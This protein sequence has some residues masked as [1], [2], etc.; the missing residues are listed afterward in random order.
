MNIINDINADTPVQAILEAEGTN[1]RA[2]MTRLACQVFN[3]SDGRILRAY[4]QFS[5]QAMATLI[6]A[7][8]KGV[9]DYGETIRKL[10]VGA[11][12]FPNNPKA[13]LEALDL[14][15]EGE[16]D[17]VDL[18][19]MDLLD[20][21]GRPVIDTTRL[22]PTM[23]KP[24][25]PKPKAEKPKE[26]GPTEA[27]LAELKAEKEAAERKAAEEE[28]RRHEA[29]KAEKAEEKRRQEVMEAQRQ[30]AEEPAA[31]VSSDPLSAVSI[32]AEKVVTPIREHIANLS[33]NLGEVLEGMHK[34]NTEAL[35]ALQDEMN[36]T[37]AQTDVR[38]NVIEQNQVALAKALQTFDRNVQQILMYF[39]DP[40][41]EFEQLPL[42]D[43]QATESAAET[44]ESAA[45]TSP[46]ESEESG[47]EPD[48]KGSTVE[49]ASEHADDGDEEDTVKR[50]TKEEL[51]AM[52]LPDLRAYAESIGC[53]PARWQKT[54][55]NRILKEYKRL[56][57][58][59]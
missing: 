18:E 53:T 14:A 24:R 58:G 31:P 4:T 13:V 43:F 49:E 3:K 34:Q 33:T 27:E 55:V 1:K 57:S 38:L 12:S 29:A 7:K 59:E 32:L 6:E 21:E 46:E 22:F 8:R 51:E 52:D 2:A 20:E 17:Q 41:M 5:P 30:Q 36:Q 16:Y 25:A 37:S 45:E 39:V 9:F 50:Y 19:A 44:S 26:T 23:K 56:D 48:D 15:T 42:G 28:A 47:Y 54:N 40:H 11:W 10:S 35:Q